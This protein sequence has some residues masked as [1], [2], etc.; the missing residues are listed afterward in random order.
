VAAADVLADAVGL[1]ALI[2]GSAR[3][4]SLVL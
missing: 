3:Y 4:G 1:A 2:A